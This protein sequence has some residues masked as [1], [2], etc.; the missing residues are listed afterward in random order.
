MV[1]LLVPLLYPPGPR[2]PLTGAVAYGQQSPGDHFSLVILDSWPRLK[3]TARSSPPCSRQAITRSSPWCLPPMVSTRS[4]GR[5]QSNRRTNMATSERALYRARPD[6][7]EVR[8]RLP[9]HLPMKRRRAIPTATW[10]DH[11]YLAGQLRRP[12]D[13]PGPVRVPERPVHMGVL[14][15]FGVHHRLLRHLPVR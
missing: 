9:P 2:R 1:K 5:R 8:A 15:V 4:G 12:A 7:T 14:A 11:P 6:A 3:R 10:P 13:Q